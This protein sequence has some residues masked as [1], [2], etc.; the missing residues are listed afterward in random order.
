ML[1]HILEIA[2]GVLAVLGI[3]AALYT[4]IRLTIGLSVLYLIA[5]GVLIALSTGCAIVRTP[6]G[7]SYGVGLFDYKSGDIELSTN[8]FSGVFDGLNVEKD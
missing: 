5:L 7:N 8:P 3:L 4:R 2:L 6:A 1:V